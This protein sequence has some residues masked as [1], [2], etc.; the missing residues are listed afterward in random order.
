MSTAPGEGA[1]R[2]R[3]RALAKPLDMEEVA[4]R[5][6]ELGHSLERIGRDLGPGPRGV[7]S[8]TVRRQMMRAGLPIRPVGFN[9]TRG[10]DASRARWAS[11]KDGFKY[12]QI[13]E[14]GKKYPAPY[15]IALIAREA[16]VSYSW[17]CHVLNREGLRDRKF[18]R[19]RKE[20]GGDSDGLVQH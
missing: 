20:A 8:M 10:Q 15:P 13:I 5:Y 19:R 18:T 1:A 14:L 9:S 17:A 12:P 16:G 2:R 7:T 11:Q 6:Y 4:Y 3:P